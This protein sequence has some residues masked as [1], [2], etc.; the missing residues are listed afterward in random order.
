MAGCGNSVGC[1]EWHF[2]LKSFQRFKKSETLVKKIIEI[3]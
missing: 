2:G 3:C 1:Y